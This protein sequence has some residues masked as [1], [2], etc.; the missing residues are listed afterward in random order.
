MLKQTKQCILT[1][2]SPCLSLSLI[3]RNSLGIWKKKK[4]SPC[5]ARGCEPDLN[6]EIKSAAGP[7]AGAAVWLRR[8]LV[9]LP[10]RDTAP[11]GMALAVP[12]KTAAYQLLWREEEAVG[13]RRLMQGAGGWSEEAGRR[14][15]RGPKPGDINKDEGKGGD[16]TLPKHECRQ[17]PDQAAHLFTC[18]WFLFIYKHAR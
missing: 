3:P 14:E 7:K 5:L 9:L 4:K 2:F 8:W 17:R 13:G 12:P 10:T 15:G 6:L 1:T 18:H 16:C 11:R